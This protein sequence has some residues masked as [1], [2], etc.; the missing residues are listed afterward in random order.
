MVVYQA[1]AYNEPVLDQSSLSLRGN[2]FPPLSAFCVNIPKME[3]ATAICKSNAA[4]GVPASLDYIPYANLML[5]LSEDVLA[6]ACADMLCFADVE[7]LVLA[8]SEAAREEVDP[9]EIT[10]AISLI[11]TRQARVRQKDWLL[12]RDGCHHSPIVHFS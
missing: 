5:T 12:P 8:L 6:Q 3:I 10:K 4:I 9:G 11:S 2:P 1:P 7:R